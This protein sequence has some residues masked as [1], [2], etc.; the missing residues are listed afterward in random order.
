M[1]PVNPDPQHCLGVG[2]VNVA[3]GG[4]DGGLGLLVDG[5]AR[6]V[7]IQLGGIGGAARL[8]LQLAGRR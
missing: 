8:I 2:P 6:L 7:L 1:D 5:A 4:T 3:E